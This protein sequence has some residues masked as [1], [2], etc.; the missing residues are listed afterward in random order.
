[1]IT[2]IIWKSFGFVYW[3]IKDEH[4]DN[5]TGLKNFN[6]AKQHIRSIMRQ[7]TSQEICFQRYN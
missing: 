6:Q 4:Q 1:M 5:I 7:Q 3:S 2:I